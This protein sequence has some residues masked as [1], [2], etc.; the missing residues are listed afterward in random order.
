MALQTFGVTAA[1]VAAHHFP[2]LSGGFSANSSPTT[3][4]VGEMIDA[5]AARLAGKLRAKAVTPS[6][7]DNSSTYPEA[8]NWCADTIRLG[9]AV[10]AARAMVGQNPAVVDAWEKELAARYADLTKHGYIA[11]GDAPEPSESAT[12][13]RTHIDE[14]SLT[15]GTSDTTLVSSAEPTFRIKDR[16]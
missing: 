9:A 14:L 11:L 4:T 10:R 5:E 1:K 3:T 15:T 6:T 7:V 13:P 12:G 8:Y 16:Q 2:Q